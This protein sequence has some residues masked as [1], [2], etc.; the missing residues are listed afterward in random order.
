LSVGG[1]ATVEAGGRLA[2]WLP[3]TL[4]GVCGAV[5]I[6]GRL[7]GLNQSLWGDELYSAKFFISPGP[8]GIWS[9]HYIANDH[10]LFELLAWATARITGSHSE[11]TYRLWAVLPGLAAAAI[12]TAWA[13]RRLG[14]WVAVA[15][16]A[17]IAASPPQL[18]LTTEARGYGLGMLASTLLLIAAD[19]MRH[20]RSRGPLIL[21]CGSAIAGIWTLPHFVIPFLVVSAIL[22]TV[23]EL[24]RQ[25]LLAVVVVAVASLAW[26][27]PVLSVMLSHGGLPPGALLPWHGFIS[28]PFRDQLAPSVS[29]LLPKLSLG[30]AALIGGL[31]AAGGA[32]ILW[33]RSE[34]WLAALVLV[35]AV[36]TYLVFEVAGLHVEPRFGSIELMPLL[37]L[38]GV[39]LAEVGRLLARN[40]VLTL[41]TIGLAA[42]LIITALAKIEQR[43]AYDAA[44]PAENYKQ[45]ASIVKVSGI[46][47]V[48]TGSLAYNLGFEYYLGQGTDT[49]MNAAGLQTLFCSN[50]TPLFAYLENGLGPSVNA[51]CL[52][53]RGAIR[54]AVPERRSHLAVWI[55][56]P[57]STALKAPVPG[58]SAKSGGPVRAVTS[59]LPQS[60]AAQASTNQCYPYATPG[61]LPLGAT[62]SVGKTLEER[63]STRFAFSLQPV[64]VTLLSDL[65]D[66]YGPGHPTLQAHPPGVLVAVTYKLRNLGSTPLGA[67]SVN[68]NIGIAFDNQV[69][70]STDWQPTSACKSASAALTLSQGVLFVNDRL[71]PGAT[72][73][74]SGLFAV[75]PHPRS[76]ELVVVPT[77]DRAGLPDPGAAGRTGSA[78]GAVAGKKRH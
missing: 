14:R 36:V 46:T 1:R 16:A 31:I 11:A 19:E 32:L 20:R 49:A 76:L 35:P 65:P 59:T 60:Q 41:A 15:V 77:G 47:R 6:W 22:L 72:A 25:V 69:W 67:R 70:R 39:G 62:L 33:F 3:I 57:T 17:V 4:I 42:A 44:V 43:A 58:G 66:R 21:L 10:I 55:V 61:V 71:A 40:K 2:R 75:P 50:A 53:E 48:V 54:V 5:V 12:M 8:S 63:I 56:P 34:R 38:A 78:S 28:G 26:Y 68:D 13:W 23:A 51:K 52:Q 27:A 45:A 18:E 24:R 74:S 37:F 9:Q 29:L 30:L 73:T 64:A 7:P